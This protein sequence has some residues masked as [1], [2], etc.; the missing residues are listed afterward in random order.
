MMKIKAKHIGYAISIIAVL[1]FSGCV[2]PFDIQASKA[3]GA[4]L[5]K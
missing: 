3:K 5:Y 4:V 2:L 1:L